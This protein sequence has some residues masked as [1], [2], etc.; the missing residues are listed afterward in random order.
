MIASD[1]VRNTLNFLLFQTGWLVCVLYPTLMAFGVAIALVC[2]HLVLVSRERFSELQF[3]GLGTVAGAAL[4]TLWLQTG[5]LHTDTGDL[6]VAPPWLVALWALFM[7]TLCHSLKWI[8]QKPWLPFVL[9]PI[10]GPF[11]YWSAGQLGA[12]TFTDLPLSL[13][14]LALGWGLLFP[15]L[16]KIRGFLYPELCHA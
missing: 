4:D 2:L 9:A 13:A 14:A 5:V 6:V 16:L 11:A 10:A 15:L 12:V 1:G 3:I 7:T 8:G